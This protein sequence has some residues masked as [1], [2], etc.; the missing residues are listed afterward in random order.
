MERCWPASCPHG[1]SLVRQWAELHR[2]E[3]LA[4]WERGRRQEP[5][6]KIEPLA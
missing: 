3:L 5:L 2:D 6:Q 1:T 4:N